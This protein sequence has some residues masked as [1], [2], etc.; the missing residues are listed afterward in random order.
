MSTKTIT[1]DEILATTA[2]VPGI[3]APFDKKIQQV[4]ARDTA[5]QLAQAERGGTLTSSLSED[6]QLAVSKIMADRD[7]AVARFLS[8]TLTAADEG[9][10]R[11]AAKVLEPERIAVQAHGELAAYQQAANT[12]RRAAG[13]PQHPIVAD[14][15]SKVRVNE[16]EQKM[17][18]LNQPAQARPAV[19]PPLHAPNYADLV[20]SEPLVTWTGR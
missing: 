14:L 15:D 2:K 6:A 12:L 8:P 10:K 9:E 16:L 19:L 3:R 20:A 1:A 18:R 13:K 5:H 7:A 17:A 11:L 4:I